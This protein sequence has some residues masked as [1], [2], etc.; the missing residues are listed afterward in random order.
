MM[1]VFSYMV[2]N[3]IK[4]FMNDFSVFGKSL[5]ECFEHLG[6]VLQGCEDTNLVL[7][8]EKYHFMVQE[9]IMLG[10][11]IS[12]RGIE[13]DKAKIQ[14][15]EKLPPPVTVKGVRSFLGHAGFYRRFIKDFSK[16][17][18]P[19]CNLL[20]KGAPF[21]FT[22]E[23]LTAFNTLKE[24]LVSAPVLTSLDWDYPFELMCDAVIMRWGYFWVNARKRG[25]M[26]FT[27]PV[28]LWM[29]LS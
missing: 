11:L 9:G 16:I 21:H 24:K 12:A 19:L 13:V 17:S 7:N 4:V 26:S 2:G 14:V 15:I 28:R 22:E 5:M 18:K 1:S 8:W 3:I 20:E 23:C 27:T 10:H 29:M 6:K 25:L